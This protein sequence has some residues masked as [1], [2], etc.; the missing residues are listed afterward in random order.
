M[1]QSETWIADFR[2][3]GQGRDGLEFVPYVRNGREGWMLRLAEGHGTPVTVPTSAGGWHE[4]HLGFWGDS[5]VRVRLSG[6]PWFDWVETTVRWDW[7][8]GSGEEAFWKIADLTG[9]SL[10]I[11]PMP[12]F[13]R[14]WTSH[15]SQIAYVRLVKISEAEAQRRLREIQNSPTR[16]AGAV[17]DGHEAIGANCPTSPDEVRAMIAGFA[18]SD[19]KRLH[20][21]CTCTT[22]RVLWLSKVG[23]Y[24]GQD[25][26][27]ERLNSDVNRRCRL[28]FLAAEEQGYD[29]LDVLIRFADENGMELWPSFRIQ[30]DYPAD[31][32][33]GFGY[34]FN[35]PIT[36]AHAEWRHVDRRGQVCSHWFSH[37]HPGWEQYKLD[38]LAEVARKGPPGIH[39]NLMC[40]ADVLW[41]FAP[42]A[43]AQFRE[44]YGIDPCAGDQ[45][46][47]EWYRFRCDHLTAFMRRFREQTNAIGRQVGRE[48]KIAVQVSGDWS[49]LAGKE[50]GARTT[51]ANFLYGF[52]IRRWA[53]EGLVDV[54]APSFRRD[55]RPMFLDHVYEE[56]GEARRRIEL[57]PSIGQYHPAVLP[58]GYDWS[59]YFTD[60]GEGRTDLVP[61]GEIDAWRILREAHDLYRQGAD[62]V[63]VWEM[64]EAPVRRARWNV[65]KH[66]GDRAML[67]REFG[68]RVS[69]MAG[70]PPNAVRFDRP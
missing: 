3:V 31:Y 34:D 68:T 66:I 67:D 37:F 58:R 7:D 35:S 1:A 49:I 25:Q 9:R 45:P 19:F 64:G 27:P 2:T 59:V 69:S 8:G 52:D 47:P 21:G 24:L 38:L 65:L 41:D 12:G 54:I 30:Q 46:P 16:T 6:E 28:A 63:D 51:P 48:I 17:I 40:E 70:D 43:V 32:A 61:F 22:M 13:E 62:S 44:Q 33:G 14:R 20:F 42:H 26:P 55:Y 29:P 4:I 53:Q 36:D 39:L 11:L 15:R 56:L 60:V 23:Y 50:F 18:G 57:A 5:G 10:E